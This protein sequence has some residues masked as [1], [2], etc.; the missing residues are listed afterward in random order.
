MLFWNASVEDLVW[1]KEKEKLV[2]QR[3]WSPVV[4]YMVCEGVKRC[5]SD[6]AQSGMDVQ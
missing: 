5:V 1:D 4:G 3:E 2:A 6:A